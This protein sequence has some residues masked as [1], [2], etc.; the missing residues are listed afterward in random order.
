MYTDK[1]KIT[2]R[3]ESDYDYLVNHGYNVLGVF[4]QGSQNYNLDYEGS[5]ID[6]KAIVIPTLEQIAMNSSMTSTTHVLDTD[7]HL[8]IKDIRLMHKCFKKQNIN[9]VEI[10]FTDYNIVNMDF[11]KDYMS[12]FDN[13]EKIA[14]YDKRASLNCM[15]GMMFRE[16]GLLKRAGDYDPKPLYHIVRLHQFIKDYIEGKPYR[17]CLCVDEQTA[18][19]FRNIKAQKEKHTLEEA[20]EIAFDLINESIDNLSNFFN[21]CPPTK[22]EEAEKIMDECLLNVLKHSLKKEVL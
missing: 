21:T 18:T 12:M 3:L 4:L 22:S 16:E 5:D 1:A 8:D 7:E 20:K 10:L 2:K 19:R 11:I 9:F 17:N 14:R 15:L 13:A 6:T